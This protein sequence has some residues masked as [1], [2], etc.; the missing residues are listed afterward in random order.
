M[1]LNHR[2][3]DWLRVTVCYWHSFCSTGS[4]VFGGGFRGRTV[5]YDH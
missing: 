1:V 4:G 5:D 3:E 2:M